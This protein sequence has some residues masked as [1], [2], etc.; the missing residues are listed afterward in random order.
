M[1]KYDHEDSRDRGLQKEGPG[2]E[3]L[4]LMYSLR[5]LVNTWSAEKK[6]CGQRKAGGAG[7]PL[8]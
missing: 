3:S 1:G 4:G 8:S 5:H 2:G 6:R 7:R